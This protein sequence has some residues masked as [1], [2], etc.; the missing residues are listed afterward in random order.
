MILS[1]GYFPFTLQLPRMQ[2][3]K[4]TFLKETANES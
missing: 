3:F 4:D 1:V 2:V